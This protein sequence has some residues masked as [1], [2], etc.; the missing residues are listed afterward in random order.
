MHVAVTGKHCFGL[1]DD[2]AAGQAAARNRMRRHG[3]IPRYVFGRVGIE[4]LILEKAIERQRVH[5]LR[6]F[7]AT[8]DSVL[9]RDISFHVVHYD[10]SAGC[11]SVCCR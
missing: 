2:D 8:E 7:V 5:A 6:D 11:L 4:A 9:V 10:V 3:N 1:R